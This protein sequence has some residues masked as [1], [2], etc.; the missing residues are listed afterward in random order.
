MQV[1]Q[2]LLVQATEVLPTEYSELG[3]LVAIDGSLINAVLSME[4]ADYRKGSKKAKIHLGFDL[5]HCIPS[6]LFLTMGKADERPFA[7]QMRI[8]DQAAR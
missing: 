6:R 3:N 5:N 1:Y 7:S 2:G 4:W 8:P